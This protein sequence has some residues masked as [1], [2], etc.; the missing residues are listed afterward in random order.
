MYVL[1]LEIKFLGQFWSEAPA[2][3]QVATMSQFVNKLK[4]KFSSIAELQITLVRTYAETET[5]YF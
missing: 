4:P 2:I 5:I 1:W 3:Q